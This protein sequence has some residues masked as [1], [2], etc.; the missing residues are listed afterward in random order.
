MRR[1]D[2]TSQVELPGGSVGKDIA[3]LS[4]PSCQPVKKNL[5]I[6]PLHRVRSSKIQPIAKY[7]GIQPMRSVVNRGVEVTKVGRCGTLHARIRWREGRW[8]AKCVG[9]LILKQCGRLL[10]SCTLERLVSVL[11]RVDELIKV[12]IEGIVVVLEWIVDEIECV[13]HVRWDIWLSRHLW[14][15]NELIA[16]DVMSLS[17]EMFETVS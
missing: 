12:E 4:T 9:I 16:R 1:W 6:H 17:D 3:S 5:L 10:L 8:T 13:V 14:F 2:V 7:G 11:E 15:G